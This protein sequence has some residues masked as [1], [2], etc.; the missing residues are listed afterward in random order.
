V[1]VTQAVARLAC[2]DPARV[3]ELDPVSLKGVAEPVRL[4]RIVAR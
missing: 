2:L 4:F 3:E 1:L